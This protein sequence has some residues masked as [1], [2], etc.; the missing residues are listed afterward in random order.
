MPQQG[1][2]LGYQEGWIGS[3]NIDMPAVPVQDKEQVRQGA[4]K[5]LVFPLAPED[6]PVFLY[7]LGGT[8][9]NLDPQGDGK[10]KEE[11]DDPQAYA[12]NGYNRDPVDGPAHFLAEPAVVNGPID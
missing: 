6:G 7:Q 4:D 3:F 5:G 11:Q 8:P 2:F 12:A 9:G 10:Q 1:I